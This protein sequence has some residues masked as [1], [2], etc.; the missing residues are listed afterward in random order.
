MEFLEEI[1]PYYDEKKESRLQES[2][3][4][5]D[6]MKKALDFTK[7]DKGEHSLPHLGFADWNDSVNLRTGAESLFNAHLYGKDLL[8]MIELCGY[9]GDTEFDHF[10][11]DM[12]NRTSWDGEWYV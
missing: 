9:L 6:H 3:T 1:I 4:V 7:N 12:F 10:E 11:K 2:G 5:L 8:E